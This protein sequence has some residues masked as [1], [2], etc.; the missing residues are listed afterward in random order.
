MVKE[1]YPAFFTGNNDGSDLGYP[2][3]L[4]HL[5]AMTSG[6]SMETAYDVTNVECDNG[7]SEANAAD[8]NMSTKNTDLSKSTVAKSVTAKAD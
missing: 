1:E 5:L 6:S 3:S 4:T 8:S 2:S 7:L